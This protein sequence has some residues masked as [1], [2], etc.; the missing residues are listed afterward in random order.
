VAA[1][2]LVAAAW[3]GCG[4]GGDDETGATT[5]PATSDSGT[6]AAQPGKEAPA[7]DEVHADPKPG[8]EV[9]GYTQPTTP[10]FDARRTGKTVVIRYRF[11]P[12]EGDEEE[13]W[14]LV[15][16]IDP[17]GED[18]SPL[19]LR[20]LLEGKTSGVIRQPLGI[21]DPPYE[22]LVS[23]Q[24]ANGLRSQIVRIPLPE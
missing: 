9:Q 8:G 20:T 5:S 17:A 19:T 14:M 7:A 18:T 16:G 4:G 3:V 13:P 24:A 15:T 11:P 22:L 23:A 10:E 2:V 21:G 1:L 6:P 12:A